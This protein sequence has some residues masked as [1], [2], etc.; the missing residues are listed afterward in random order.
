MNDFN[1][2]FLDEST[3]EESGTLSN[4]DFSLENV[5]SKIPQFSS[6]KLCNMIICSRYLSIYQELSILCMEE[7]S[8][9]RIAGDNFDFENHIE[10]NFQNLPKIEVNLPDIRSIL[11]K[12]I[13]VKI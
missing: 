10:K 13:G 3:L 12:S 1:F 7:L 2:D 11:N 6:Q 5:K 8:N 4:V 9:R